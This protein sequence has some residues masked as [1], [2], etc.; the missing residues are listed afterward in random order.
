MGKRYIKIYSGE[1]EDVLADTNFASMLDECFK[2]DNYY[3]IVEHF[4]FAGGKKIFYSSDWSVS[5]NDEFDPTQD[6]LLI[7]WNLHWKRNE[8]ESKKEQIEQIQKWISK[9]GQ[10][11]VTGYCS[12]SDFFTPGLFDELKRN[13]GKEHVFG[14][15]ENYMKDASMMKQLAEKSSS[16][17]KKFFDK[18]EI[19]DDSKPVSLGKKPN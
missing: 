14:R 17:V 2:R 8:V 15:F 10:I 7:L 19:I 4:Y 1:P 5:I 6:E 13:F 11:K 18:L 16:N 3:V 12:G 9:G